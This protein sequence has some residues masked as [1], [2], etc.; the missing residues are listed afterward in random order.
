MNSS[1]GK[2]S[3]TAL[4]TVVEAC[5]LQEISRRRI[6][7]S[8]QCLGEAEWKG[9]LDLARRQA[10][11]FNLR[12]EVS[13]YRDRHGKESSLLDYVRKRGKWPSSTNRW[14]TSEFKRGPGGRV[15][16]MLQREAPGDVLNVFGF[17]AE[18]SPARSRKP[19]FAK[20]LRFSNQSREVWDWLPIH[21]MPGWEVWQNIR[22]SGVPSH[23]AYDLGMSRLSCVFCIFAPRAALLLAGIN[24]PELLDEYC[25]VEEETGH[26][27]KNGLSLQSVRQAIKDGEKPK[28]TNEQWN[29]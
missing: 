8:H 24:N 2:D 20:N 10:E 23:P 1:G 7:V 18:E 15:I 5:D 11:H 28:L 13:K 29:M 17:R 26:T 25:K 9:T 12:F 14:C 27:F 6:V 19:V 21:E 16:T 3:Q 22:D 4:R